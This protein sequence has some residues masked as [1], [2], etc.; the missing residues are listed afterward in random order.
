MSPANRDSWISRLSGDA[1]VAVGL[2]PP[3]TRFRRHAHEGPHLCGV[4]AGG[5][6]EQ[7]RGGL[8]SAGAGTVRFSPAASH[9]ID[10][11]PEGARCVVIELDALPEGAALTRSRFLADDWLTT[12]LARAERLVRAS[13]PGAPAE[14]DQFVSELLA[15]L[16]RR[17]RPRA[18][19][20]PPAWLLSVR[21]TLLA[22]R[23]EALALD[24][25]AAP[26]GIHRAHLAR[27]FRDHYGV[28]IGAFVRRLRVE[29]ALDLLRDRERSLAAIALDAGFADQSHMT[30]AFVARLGTTPARL[31][32]EL[33]G[34]R[35]LPAVSWPDARRLA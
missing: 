9:H 33:A 18:G 13:S 20:T 6:V 29:R 35:R 11:G 16:L 1:C 19:G 14:L 4:L 10:F 30:R 17:T 27:A 24:A 12:L 21:E 22:H 5:F 28:T 23:G 31:R 32:R 8:A 34:T 2:V 15:Q 3:G 25:L 26:H 7:E